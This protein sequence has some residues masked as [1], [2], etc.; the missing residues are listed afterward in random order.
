MSDAVR[1]I[2][3]YAVGISFGVAVAAG[4]FAFITTVVC[5]GECTA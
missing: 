5:D 4:L 2:V 1:T 3:Y